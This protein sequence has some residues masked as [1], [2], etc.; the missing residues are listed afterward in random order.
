MSSGL[1]KAG[2]F[3]LGVPR[4]GKGKAGGGVEGGEGEVESVKR[5]LTVHGNFGPLSQIPYQ[6]FQNVFFK[7][8]ILCGPGCSQICHMLFKQRNPC[9]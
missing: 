1:N 2:L 7:I 6:D 9:P 5:E 4:R 8:S 3:C